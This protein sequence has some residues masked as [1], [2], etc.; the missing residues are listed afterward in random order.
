MPADPLFTAAARRHSASLIQAIAP[1]AQRLDRRFSAWLRKHRHSPAICRALLAVTPAAA[2]R[3]RSLDRFLEQ[4]ETNGRYLARCNVSPGQ[5]HEALRQFGGWLA[6]LLGNRF[7]PSREQLYLA[8]VLALD[9]AYYQVR[10]AEAQALFGIYRAEAEAAGVE[11]LLRRV[12]NILTRTFRARV[13]R[14]VLSDGPL[15]GA[16]ARP[17][18]IERSSRAVRWISD[19]DLHGRYASYWSFPL[20]PAAAIQLAFR[21][22]CPW[23]PRELTLLE[24]AAERCRKAVERAALETRLRQFEAQARHA[25]EQERRRIGRELHDET[26]QLLLLLRL[27]LEMLERGAAPEQRAGLAEARGIVERTVVELRRI[28]A[29]LSPAQLERLGLPSALRQLA[30]RME[31]LHA[32]PVTVRISAAAGGFPQPVQEVIYRVAQECLQNVAKHSQAT[33]VNLFLLLTDKLIRLSVADNG[34]GF[35]PDAAARQSMSFGLAGMHERAALVGGKLSVRSQQNKG[36]RVIL[37]LP[38][39]SA[40]VKTNGKDSRT[41]N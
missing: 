22:S 6:K 38:L 32:A 5:V 3:V 21:A 34:I 23:L 15:A 28:I 8:T 11:D 29:A 9:R 2:A 35:H 25:E 4:V 36:T 33:H 26:G 19:P 39:P 1:L 27:R 10:E 31:R 13:G 37:E 16:L 41:V 12:T 40:P 14:L 24:T 30:S 17:L 18:Y 20:A 7:A